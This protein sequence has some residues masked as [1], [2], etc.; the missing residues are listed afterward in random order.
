MR[1]AHSVE[2]LIN[3]KSAYFPLPVVAVITRERFADRAARC[4]LLPRNSSYRR[5]VNTARRTKSAL[6]DQ[7]VRREIARHNCRRNLSSTIQKRTH[8]RRHVRRTHSIAEEPYLIPPC[9][10]A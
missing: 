3:P 5:N 4:N 8:N 6:S 10:E 1:M 7:A 2:R 9:P